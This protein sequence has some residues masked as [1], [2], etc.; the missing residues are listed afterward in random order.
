MLEN[1]VY[2][3][4]MSEIARRHGIAVAALHFDGGRGDPASSRCG[5]RSRRASAFTHVAVVHHET[6][7][8]R[9][10]ELAPL[11]ALCREHGAELLVDAVS[12]FGAEALDLDAWGIAACAATAHKCLHGALGHLV[13]DRAPRRA[14][15]QLPSAPHA[16]PRPAQAGRA[17]RSAAARRSRR[18]CPRSTRCA[19]RS[20]SS[21]RRAAGAARRARYRALAERIRAALAAHGIEPWLAPAAS[22]VVLRSYRLP[23]GAAPTTS[24]H[25]ELKKRGF[26]IYAGQAPLRDQLF[27]ISTMGEISDRDVD[28]FIAAFGELR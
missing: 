3:E 19:R 17:S 25:D 22:S 27:R 21:P 1:G 28:R 14:R 18:S 2:G 16:L 26:V 24:L 6:T 5:A 7:T 15:A 20:T 10:N 13:R 23:G 4:R 12:S 8:G 9:L 11:G